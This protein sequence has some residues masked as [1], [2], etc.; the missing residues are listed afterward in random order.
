MIKNIIKNIPFIKR[1]L[2]E[3]EINKIMETRSKLRYAQ[4]FD[5]LKNKKVKTIMEIGT[6]NGLQGYIMIKLCNKNNTNVEY[7]GFD[8][9]NEMTNEI[10][11]KEISKKPPSKNDVMEMLQLTGAKVYLFGGN[12]TKTLPENINKLPLMDFIFIDGGHSLET[13]KNDWYYVQKV[14]G[15]D[16]IVIF[17]DYWEGRN[18]AGCKEIIEGIDQKKFKVEILPKQDC[19]EKKDGLLKISLVKVTL[20]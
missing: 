11:K 9:F 17:D 1:K 6:W 8:L 14:I 12:T 15:K 13:I 10:F 7:Y 20:T 19:F 18:D 5:I 2:V 4:I 16:S 3:R